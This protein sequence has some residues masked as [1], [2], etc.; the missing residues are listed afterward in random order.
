M[1]ARPRPRP[2]AGPRR[3]WAS[4]GAAA[5]RPAGGR[6]SRRRNGRRRRGRVG[7]RRRGS[8]RGSRSGGGGSGRRRA[9]RLGLLGWRGGARHCAHPRRGRRSRR[10]GDVEA[11]L[12][13]LEAGHHAL[14][15]VVGAGQQ[16]PGAQQLEQEARRGGPAHLRQARRHDVGGTAELDRAEPRGLGDQALPGVLGH[17]DQA[18]GGGVGHG[19]DDDEVAQ[20]AQQVLGEAARVLTGLHDLVDHREDRRAVARG[21]RLDHLVEQGLGGEAEQVGGQLV[22]HAR[23]ARTAEQLV[24]HG[25]RVARRPR[26]G[27]DDERQGGRLDRHALLGRQLGEVVAQQPRR[28][29]PEGVVVGARADRRQ[30]LVGLGRGEDEAQVR[31]RLLDQ[32]EQGVEAL[33]GDHVGLVDDVDLVAVAHR[34]EERLLAQVARVVHTT[35]GGRVDLDDVHRPRAAAGQL[36]T[37]VALAARVRDRSLHTVEGAGEDA[38]R[39]RLAAAAWTGEEIGVVDP[40]G[41]ERGPERLRHVVLPDDL[42]EGLGPVAAIERER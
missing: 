9:G 2:P 21:E 10:T 7:A 36:A 34:C 33:R 25:Q 8:R 11:S 41:R 35:V 24:E 42:L 23:L 39:R 12:Q 17:V 22:G 26:P 20:P 31:R 5:G 30:H 3:R 32:L 14:G 29:Q 16:H 38:G 4:A 40:V 28:D 27:P 13:P 1:Q 18:G 19:G 6:R 37:A 15:G